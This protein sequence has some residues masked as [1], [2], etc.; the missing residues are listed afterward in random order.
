MRDNALAM[1]VLPRPKSGSRT[2]A[3]HFAAWATVFS[4]GICSTASPTSGAVASDAPGAA[5][6]MVV[7][8]EE[9]KEYDWVETPVFS[10]D[11]KLF[12]YDAKTGDKHL[13]VLD[14]VEQE[15]MDVIRGL[16]TDESG[17]G[18]IVWYGWQ[19]ERCD[20]PSEG[21]SGWQPGSK[22]YRFTAR[23]D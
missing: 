9:H 10:P 23:S 14:G 1:D 4:P 3:V 13:V 21:K 6:F 16:Q 15:P 5:W 11:S 20:S 12:A 17:E 7:D 8:G 19:G 18:G 2:L 22:L